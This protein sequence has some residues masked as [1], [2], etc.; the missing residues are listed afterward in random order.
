MTF[1][2][3]TEFYNTKGYCPGD[4]SRRQRARPLNAK[5]LLRRWETTER[6]RDQVLEH[7]EA[8]KE[9]LD[10]D[11][12]TR[13]A[14]RKRDGMRCRLVAKI[15][16]STG[17]GFLHQNL[18]DKAGPLYIQLDVAHVFGKGSHPWMRHDLDNVVLLNRYSHNMLDQG[19]HPIYGTMINAEE[20]EM[21]WIWIL[22]PQVSYTQ[23][24]E[25]AKRRP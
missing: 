19:K 9:N 12:G 20:R 10:E 22:T 23:L 17:G 25:K 6:S 3:F 16:S 11:E 15:L 7:A 2:A 8:K 13:R 4:V 14:C 18:K 24:S 1:E 21:W 5:E